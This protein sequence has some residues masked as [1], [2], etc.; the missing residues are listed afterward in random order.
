MDLLRKLFSAIKGTK[1]R[2]ILVFLATVVVFVTTYAL[3]LPAITLEQQ[4][5]QEQDGIHLEKQEENSEQSTL[6]A[7]EGQDPLIGQQAN[8]QAVKHDSNTEA[9]AVETPAA[10]ETSPAESTVST[11]ARTKVA[12]EEA[13]PPEEEIQYLDAG[14][15]VFEDKNWTLHADFEQEALLPV[16]TEI[17]VKELNQD[18]QEYAFF[19]DK[20][21][22]ALEDKDAVAEAR[23]YD[24]SLEY[25][26][27]K[28]QP[29]KPMDIRI[30][31]RS[32]FH[33]PANQ[34]LMAVHFEEEHQEQPEFLPVEEEKEADEVSS[35]RFEAKGFSTYGLLSSDN[36]TVNRV[37]IDDKDYHTVKFIYQDLEGKEQEISNLIEK[38]DNA[39]LGELPQA[40]FKEGF[41]F[42]GWVNRE[43]GEFVTAET[44]VIGDMILDGVFS[45]ISIYT[46]RVQ[47]YYVSQTSQEEVVFD[48]EIFQLEERDLP[49]L[50]TPPE[51]T[52]L[53]EKDSLASDTIYYA[54]RSQLS[55]NR[56]DLQRLDG[57]DGTEDYQVMM[58]L[59]YKPANTEFTF[60]YKVRDLQGSGYTTF[61]QVKG[62][63][64]VGSPVEPQIL[65]FP[66]MEFERADSLTLDNTGSQEL[67]HYYR[68]LDARL[69]YDSQGGSYIEPL[70]AP[71]GTT[72]SITSIQPIKPGFEFRGWYD[73]PNF[74]GTAKSGT[75]VL[76]KDTQLYAK[77]ERKKVDFKI[78]YMREMYNNASQHIV[79]VYH[80]TKTAQA[81]VGETITASSQ[82]GL[83]D[84]PFYYELDTERNQGSTTVITEDGTASLVV[85]Y[86]L[87]R[88]DIVF[89]VEDPRFDTYIKGLPRISIN[90][91]TYRGSEYRLRGV[92]V[93]QDLSSIWP[94]SVD[95]PR[96]V[97]LSGNPRPHRDGTG[98]Y[99]IGWDDLRNNRP[100]YSTK[101]FELTPDVVESAD[102]KNT[103][104][105]RAQFSFKG[106]K[107]KVEYWLQDANNPNL[108]QV[109]TRFSQE[110]YSTG[111]VTQKEI[112]GFTKLTSP[113]SGGYNGTTESN[114][115]KTYRFYYKRNSFTLDYVYGSSIIKSIPNLPFGRDISSP[116][117]S[118]EPTRPAGVDSD[119]IWRGWY[120]DETFKVPVQWTVM[121][122]QNKVVYA[123]WE[124][125]DYTVSFDTNGGQGQFDNMTVPKYNKVYNPGAPSLDNHRFMGWYTERT[126]GTLYDWNRPVTGNITLYARW[127]PIA[128]T[129]RVRYLEHNTSR[130]LSADLLVEDPSLQN[131]QNI[132]VRAKG[133]PGYLPDQLRQ[134]V[135]LHYGENLITF[136]YTPNTQNITYTIRYVL[137]SNEAI[138]VAPTRVIDVEAGFIFAKERPVEVDKQ[139]MRT[140]AGVT[141][142]M[143]ATDYFALDDVQQIYFTSDSR[144]NILTFRYSDYDT[145]HIRVNYLDMDGNP[146]PGINPLY[147]TRKRPSAYIVQRPGIEGYSYHHS[148]DHQQVE[149]KIYYQIN[150]S[151][152]ITI[153]LYYQKNLLIRAADKQ[154]VYDGTALVS[155]GLSDLA[156]VDGLKPTDRLTSIAYDGSQTNAGS[157]QTIPKEARISRSSGRTSG[158]ANLSQDFY[159][160]TYEAGSLLVTKQPVTVTVKGQK[161]EKTYDGLTTRVGYEWT[162]SDDSGLYQ[163]SDI[164]LVADQSRYFVERKDAGTYT[165]DLYHLF[166]NSNP[167]FDVRFVIEN[168]SLTIRP[169]QLIFTSDSAEQGYDGLELRAESVA[170]SVPTGVDYT[171]LVDGETV[172]FNVLGSQINPGKGE[173]TF[174]YSFGP[175]TL[176]SNYQVTVQNGQLTVYPTLN[177]QKTS[178][179]WTPLAGGKF[180]LTK[181]DG[182]QWVAV[183]EIDTILIDS[184]EGA[185][186][187][188]LKAGTYRLK[189]L[190]AP[191]GFIVLTEDIYFTVAEENQSF[192]LTLT[193][194]TGQAGRP[195]MARFNHN[196]PSSSTGE[197]ISYSHRLQV[198]NQP[199]TALPETG[200]LGRHLV[201]GIGLVLMFGAGVSYYW[202]KRYY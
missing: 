16:G 141:E 93:G 109:A 37:T 38:T 90:G 164:E 181:W 127:N 110:L 107:H 24:I 64:M 160:I 152:E 200:G 121:Y 66:Y 131:G 39:K 112:F 31:Y 99:F 10:T 114:G 26:G 130:Q 60:V 149:N 92:V 47:Y 126:G 140:Q 2:R 34:G 187:V 83:T 146:I 59:A 11:E 104:Q 148:I 40:P 135:S 4:L 123:K 51:S 165:L 84:M 189:E 53:L 115:S 172:E 125:P 193:D 154:K 175:N 13:S 161:Q 195:E 77:W 163:E 88:Y 9:T 178:H 180:E 185:N 106:T 113:P 27:Q 15:L 176:E 43:T 42:D 7:I 101:R 95:N 19:L 67:V 102:N 133:I 94:S 61:H 89:D 190:A 150:Q 73:N 144:K 199:G 63:G 12:S 52:K 134:T 3:V 128:T 71:Y 157:S 198:A 153:N 132:T 168:G 58:R 111:S 118:E 96:E 116:S 48:T 32:T 138:E 45:P 159:K 41:R 173:N 65:A 81:F 33:L 100:V 103:V 147:V 174:T 78:V 196:Q 186:L 191:D 23:F 158:A 192:V 80:Q 35:I 156:L 145:A 170:I 91:Q 6:S 75:V 72:V 169:R 20:T 136:Y 50:I 28:I 166:R 143:L 171:G 82:P 124:K 182:R 151:Q 68:R 162:I 117:Y 18:S 1:Y 14:S 62:H 142:S 202:K 183:P 25:N 85:Y 54:E 86:R 56:G 17:Q 55:I 46:V 201:M 8:E 108:Y 139:H 74:T 69:Y 184:S 79:T 21:K 44:P 5:A 197:L 29:Q 120:E 76:D 122:G 30:D 36:R 188:G 22:E 70:V 179:H 167:N 105:L 129:Y 155:S 97:Y 177:L 49:H 98:W 194:Q 137:A 87:K 119:F 57:L